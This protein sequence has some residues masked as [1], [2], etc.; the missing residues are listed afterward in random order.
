MGNL[1]DATH[2]QPLDKIAMT[3]IKVQTDERIARCFPSAQHNFY[4]RI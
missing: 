4:D 2:G 3:K 1:V